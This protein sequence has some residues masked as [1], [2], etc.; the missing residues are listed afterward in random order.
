[1][2]TIKAV[3]EAAS[4]LKMPAVVQIT[5]KSLNYAGDHEIATLAR[6]VIENR[7]NKNKIA[8]HLDH[9]KSFKICKKAIQLGFTSVMIDGSGLSY[10]ENQN[11]TR[12]VVEYAHRFK[13]SVQG[14]LG[15]VPYL[16]EHLINKINNGETTEKE[17]WDRFMTDPEKAEDFVKKTGIDSLA[18]AIGNAHGHQKER[19]TPDWPRLEEIKKKVRIPLILHGSSDWSQY[20]V[21]KAVQYGI[22]CFNVDT[23]L[24]IAYIN[25]LCTLFEKDCRMQDPRDIM[26]DVRKNVKEKVKSKIKIFNPSL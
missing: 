18:V 8:L 16:G 9:G 5:Q 3:V 22:R 15:T 19:S 12:R 11:L 25:K 6:N 1:L 17:I 2:E 10:E 4:D 21:E 23:D 14:E 13:V 7:S 24:R 20:K 26:N